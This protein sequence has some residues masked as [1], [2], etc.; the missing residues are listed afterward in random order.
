[1]MMNHKKP[2]QSQHKNLNPEPQAKPTCKP[3][4]TFVEQPNK[5]Q[6]DETM[7]EPIQKANTKIKPDVKAIYLPNVSENEASNA[8]ETTSSK[9]ATS[10]PTL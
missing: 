6:N 7:L 4:S 5:S 10:C 9:H 3:K 2:N 8:G 1:M